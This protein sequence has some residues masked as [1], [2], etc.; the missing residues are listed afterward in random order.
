L[1]VDIELSWLHK[2]W[3]VAQKD[4]ERVLKFCNMELAFLLIRSA[5][6]IFPFIYSTVK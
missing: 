5:L 4:Q 2:T 1:A 6:L 3:R